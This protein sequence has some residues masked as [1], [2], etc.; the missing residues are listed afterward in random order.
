LANWSNIIQFVKILKGAQNGY[1]S[2]RPFL[3]F[4]H[5]HGLRIGREVQVEVQFWSKLVKNF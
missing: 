3:Y 2:V 5:F 4:D 1:A